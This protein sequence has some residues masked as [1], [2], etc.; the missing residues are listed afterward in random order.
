MI[1]KAFSSNAL[2]LKDFDIIHLLEQY[3]NKYIGVNV[4]IIYAQIALFSRKKTKVEELQILKEAISIVNC[5]E[6]MIEPKYVPMRVY[7]V[8][9]CFNN[10]TL[11]RLP[12][13]TF[14]NVREANFRLD[15]NVLAK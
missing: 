13:S 8:G 10:K 3:P 7:E 9:R 12:R 14:I 1:K 4:N 5:Y 6:V 11:K 2:I 15:N